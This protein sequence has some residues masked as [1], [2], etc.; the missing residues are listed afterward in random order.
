MNFPD[1]VR[2]IEELTNRD[3]PAPLAR[4]AKMTEEVG[5]LAQAVITMREQDTPGHADYTDKKADPADV[6][7]EAAD[8]MITAISVA[9]AFARYLSAVE[10]EAVMTQKLERWERWVK[11]KEAGRGRGEE[12]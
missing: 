5:E 4:L 8:V 10:L 12:A 11:I 6:V 9:S 2:K 7:E 1:I 3:D